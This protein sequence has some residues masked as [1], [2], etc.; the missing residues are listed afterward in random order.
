MWCFT[1]GVLSP[2]KRVGSGLAAEGCSIEQVGEQAFA[3]GFEPGIL[4]GPVSV[5]DVGPLLPR[6]PGIDSF[7]RP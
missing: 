4:L 5:A 7:P 3:V 6:N 1:L 2:H